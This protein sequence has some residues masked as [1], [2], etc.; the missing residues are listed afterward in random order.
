M[1]LFETIICT[2][3]SPEDTDDRQKEEE[4]DN[5]KNPPSSPSLCP[6]KISPDHL[7]Q[8]DVTPAYESPTDFKHLHNG[9]HSDGMSTKLCSIL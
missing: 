1:I 9:L 3:L 7:I 2:E 8:F 6:G 4:V 5:Q